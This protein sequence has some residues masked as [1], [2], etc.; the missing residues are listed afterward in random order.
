MVGMFNLFIEVRQTQWCLLF[1][2]EYVFEDFIAG[3]LEAEFKAQWQVEPQK[4]NKSLT[5]QGIFQMRHDIFL[6]NKKD[7]SVKIIVDTKYKLRSPDARKDPKKGISQS[8]LY[9]MTSYAFR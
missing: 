3:F 1:P 6:T 9:Q 8:D 4:S 7:T 2:M 5:D